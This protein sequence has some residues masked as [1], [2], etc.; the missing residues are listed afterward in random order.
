VLAP[1]R[2]PPTRA[3][4]RFPRTLLQDDVRRAVEKLEASYELRLGEDRL[5]AVVDED[6]FEIVRGAERPDAIVEAEDAAV[7]RAL[8]YE[9]RDLDE[10]LRSGDVRIEGDRQTVALFLTR[11]PSLQHRRYLASLGAFWP[12]CTFHL[13]CP[14]SA[15]P[16]GGPEPGFRRGGVHDERRRERLGREH[17]DLRVGGRG[18]DDQRGDE[19]QSHRGD[20]EPYGE[21]P[22]PPLPMQ[23]HPS[24]SD[25]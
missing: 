16:A 22:D 25:T 10:V 13:A 24:G 1:P 3:G 15:A 18:H 8:V 5:R 7:L 11:F 12:S 20:G 9:G 4:G 6:C 14:G 19:T 17:R 23:A 21:R 2:G